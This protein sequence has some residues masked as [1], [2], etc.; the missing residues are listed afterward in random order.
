VAPHRRVA[1]SHP[2]A[3]FRSSTQFVWCHTAALLGRILEPS[4]YTPRA[5]TAL[6]HEFP[7]DAARGAV[8][9]MD[10]LPS[11][12]GGYLPTEKSSGDKRIK[13]AGLSI[14]AELTCPPRVFTASCQIHFIARSHVRS[15]VDS[16][17]TVRSQVSSQYALKH[18]PENVL[19]YTPNCTR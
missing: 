14:P 12:S 5:R 7:L 10:S 13:R 2:R 19:K 11:S 9:I 3:R 15:E 16:C 4:A 8:L 1:L 6:S 17:L 18:T